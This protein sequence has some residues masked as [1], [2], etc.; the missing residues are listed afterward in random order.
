MATAA[1]LKARY[2]DFDEVAD[3]HVTA[4]LEDA[5][6][7]VDDSWLEDDRDRAQILLACHYLIVEAAFDDDKPGQRRYISSEKIGDAQ[8]NYYIPWQ[9][10]AKLGAE[11]LDDTTFGKR[12][13][14][15]LRQ[16]QAGPMLV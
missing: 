7:E 2:T 16:N 3:A 1:D 4:A 6:R 9:R 14:H 5:A 10:Y 12:F 13:L 11:D 15:L 8:I